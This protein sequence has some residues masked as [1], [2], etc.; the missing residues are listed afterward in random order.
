MSCNHGYAAFGCSEPAANN[1]NGTWFWPAG[2]IFTVNRSL[3]PP[4]YNA[5]RTHQRPI[6]TSASVARI[7]DQVYVTAPGEAFPEVASAI[8]RTFS[9]TDGIRDAHI[10]NHGGDQ[11]GYY[12]DKRPGVYP[13]AQLAQ[14]DF[15]RFNVG[16]GLA[17][18]NVDA[19]RGAASVIGLDG[20]VQHAY[21]EV[22]NP[23]AFSQPNI[24]FYP[25]RKETSDTT[26][27]LYATSKKAQQPGAASTTVG[28]TA[29]TQNDGKVSWDFGDGTTDV[30]ASNARFDHT[31]PGP[32]TYRV[33]ASVADNLGKTYR[34]IQTVKIDPP[35]TAGVDRSVDADGKLVLTPRAI[36]GQ[37]WDVLAAHW[38]FDD[39]SPATDGTRIV[40]DVPATPLDVT[41]TVTDGAGNTDT[42]TVTIPAGG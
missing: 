3:T 24:Q 7:G 25:D 42:R 16:P 14:S 6:G 28:S 32:G 41:V 11:L 34:W 38:T 23:R 33:Q 40:R 21:A 8:R 15:E 30:L 17:Q 19:V 22:D 10:I 9:A 37:R 13:T 20:T 36:G 18:D 26:V 2:Q 27:S 39:G 29:A 4:Y 35:L 5:G 1:G 12:W 31:F